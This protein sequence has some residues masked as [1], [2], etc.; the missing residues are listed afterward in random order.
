MKIFFAIM[1]LAC[2]RVYAVHYRYYK[3]NQ[4]VEKEF[5]KQYS[6][7]IAIRKFMTETKNYI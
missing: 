6:K 7:K 3:Q 4:R 5:R 2:A 1:F